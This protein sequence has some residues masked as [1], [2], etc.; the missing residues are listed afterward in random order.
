MAL[1]GRPTCVAK[2]QSHRAPTGP[3]PGWH[4]GESYSQLAVAR[5]YARKHDSLG[6]RVRIAHIDTGYDK[7]HRALPPAA[8][9]LRN[10][11]RDFTKHSAA[12]FADDPGGL[13][14]PLDNRGHGTATLCILAGS[15]IALLKGEPLGGAP[16]AEVLP[17]RVSERVVLAGTDALAKAVHYAIDSGCDVITLSMG[18]VASKFWVDAYNRAYENGVFCVAA[19]G[20]HLKLGSLP[21]TPASTVYPALFNRVISATGVMADG[22]PYDLPG[23]MSGNWG[24]HDKMRTALAAYTPNIPWAEFGC[25]DVVS[26]DG[27]G[28]SAATPQIAAAAALWLQ[29]NGS[30][31]PARDWR[32]VEAVRQ[33]L[34]Q[35]A[36]SPGP[37]FEEFGRGI[38]PKTLVY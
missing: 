33:A 25:P 3:E 4:L 37:H 32:R 29:V 16:D 38:A 22:L 17:L 35:S 14:L 20:N 8:Q 24:P 2:P 7:S 27:A 34:L 26:Q 12:P 6:R 15:A 9:I 10:L 28:T 30:K 19:A 36:K 21:T 13:G 18:G 5:D 1:F 31:F 11:S 23:T